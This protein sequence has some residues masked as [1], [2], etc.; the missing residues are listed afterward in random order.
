MFF[1]GD[2]NNFVNDIIFDLF[3]WPFEI[4]GNDLVESSE[5]FSES[6]VKVILDWVVISWIIDRVTFTKKIQLLLTTCYRAS[7]AVDRVRFI[8]DKSMNPLRIIFP[9]SFSGCFV[10]R[11]AM[12]LHH[13]YCIPSVWKSRSLS[14][15]IRLFR[16]IAAFSTIMWFMGSSF[17]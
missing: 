3:H 17:E 1:L 8:L 7:H 6:G 4:N 16:L 15:L 13:C 9:G 5:G 2:F 11:L 14:R 10:F 12:I